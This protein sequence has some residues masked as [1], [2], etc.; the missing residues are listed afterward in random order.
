VEIFLLEPLGRGGEELGPLLLLGEEGLVESRSDSHGSD[1][2]LKGSGQNKW[3][4]IRLL[5]LQYRC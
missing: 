2:A 5:C 1:Y 3:E 4:C